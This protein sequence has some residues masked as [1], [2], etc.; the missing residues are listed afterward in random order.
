MCPSTEGV[1]RTPPNIYTNSNKCLNN[2][3]LK[4]YNSQQRNENKEHRNSQRVPKFTS[5]GDERLKTLGNSY[6]NEVDEIKMRVNVLMS[7]AVMAW[8]EK[9]LYTVSLRGVDVVIAKV[10][11]RDGAV[12]E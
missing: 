6:I 1:N 3:L 5:E 2:P 10:T 12:S 9:A 8:E 11:V 7:S 4:Q